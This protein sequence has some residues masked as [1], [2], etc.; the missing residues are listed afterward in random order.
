[1]YPPCPA[2]DV[3]QVIQEEMRA[4]LLDSHPDLEQFAVRGSEADFEEAAGPGGAALRPGGMLSVKAA[5][6]A[7]PQVCVCLL[8]GGS[9]EAQWR[10]ARDSTVPEGRPWLIGNEPDADAAV[11]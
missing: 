1:M 3:P 6:G 9:V 2:T 5:A 10:L 11:I 8:S 4:Q 7:R